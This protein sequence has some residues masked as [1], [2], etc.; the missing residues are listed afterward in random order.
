[1]ALLEL[2]GIRESQHLEIYNITMA[3]VSPPTRCRRAR[4]REISLNG[5]AARRAAVAIR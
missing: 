4:Q 2:S 3:S 1:V 5:P